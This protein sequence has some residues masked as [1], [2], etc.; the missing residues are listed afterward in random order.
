[1]EGFREGP[2]TATQIPTGVREGIGR[3][4]THMCRATEMDVTMVGLHN[5]GKT[6]L[7]RVLS[8]CVAPVPPLAPE[9]PRFPKCTS[10][11]G[12]HGS[13]AP[14]TLCLQC[15]LSPWVPRCCQIANRLLIPGWRVHDR[16]SQPSFRRQPLRRSRAEHAPLTHSP[17]RARPTAS[18]CWFA[19]LLAPSADQD[20]V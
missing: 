7:L 14:R 12:A 2:T 6:S 5:A 3:T 11:R 9:K 10:P 20:P 18:P 17:S 1:M 15:L 13:Q 8:V 19:R 4:D 16:V